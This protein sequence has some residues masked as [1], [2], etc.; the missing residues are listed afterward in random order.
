MRTDVLG[1]SSSRL[2]WSNSTDRYTPLSKEPHERL[3]QLEYMAVTVNGDS[4]MVI[5]SEDGLLREVAH[6]TLPDEL[7]LA[8]LPI[9]D[10]SHLHAVG[11]KIGMARVFAQA[12][13]NHPRFQIIDGPHEIAAAVEL[14]GYPAVVKEAHNGGGFGITVVTSPCDLPPASFFQCG[15]PLL[16]EEFVPGDEYSIDALY[17]YGRLVV[18]SV[19]RIVEVMSSWGVSTVREFVTAQDPKLFC[20]LQAIGHELGM[21]GLANISTV[22]QHDGSYCIFEFDMRPNNWH[23]YARALGVDFSAALTTPQLDQWTV[24]TPRQVSTQQPIRVRHLTRT[25]RS[26]LRPNGGHWELLRHPA[27]VW[28]YVHIG[29][30]K[31][32]VLEGAAHARWLTDHIREAIAIR[33]RNRTH[34]GPGS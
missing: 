25:L 15:Q 13:V 26:G 1:P 9:S 23:A 3:R 20:D 28:P 30:V 24:L 5:F 14:I 8:L 19:S 7:K 33:L 16:V 27:H 18:A 31:L 17:I 12:G 22:R 32:T 4:D 6:S 2:R 21:H 34:R 10:I 29:D 11:S